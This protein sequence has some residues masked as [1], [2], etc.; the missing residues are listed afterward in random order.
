VKP[1]QGLSATVAAERLAADGPNELPQDRK[2]NVIALLFEMAREPMILLL[3]AAAVLYALIG[4]AKEAITLAASVV[5]MIA[6]TFAQEWKTERA[7]RS[8]KDLSSP[9]AQV[10]RDGNALRIPGRDVVRGD[11]VVLSEG[12]RVPADGDVIDA[13]NAL[14]DESILTGE[15]V[16]VQKLA[17]GNGESN[18]NTR[19]FSG[20]LVVRGRAMFEV[21]STGR[22]AELGKIGQALSE[23]ESE[24][25][26][27]QKQIRA[28]VRAFGFVGISS[29]TVLVLWIGLTKGDWIAGLLAGLALA[30]SLMP[31][32]FPVILTVFLA[33]GAYRMSRRHVLARRMAAVEALGAVSVLC[34]DK[35]GTLTENRMRIAALWTHGEASYTVEAAGG[36]LPERVHEV[37]EYGILSSQR[38]PFDP[39]E[40][41]FADLGL[42][43]LTGTEHLHDT[44]QLIRE[45]P[46]SAELLSISHVW[47][48][49]DGTA[50]VVAAKGAPEAIIDLCH[51]SD[52]DA[53]Q[54]WEQATTMA[55]QGLR[56]LG[57]ARAV[58]KEGPLP[59]IQ[60]DFIFTFVGLVGLADPLRAEVPA[61]IAESKQAGVR[62]IMITG[63]YVQTARTIGRSAGIDTTHVI[64]GA[65]L[66]ILSDEALA[67]RLA[68]TSIIARAIPDDKLRIVRA[69]KKSGAVVAMTGDGVNDAP[70]L[71]AAHVGIAMGGRGTDV[72]RESAGL[73]LTDDN[74]A[75]ILEGIRLGRRIFDNIRRASSYV[76]SVHV[77]IAGAALIPAL[78]GWPLSLLPVHIV[79]LELIIDPACSIA[80]EAEPGHEKAMRVPPRAIDTPILPRTRVVFALLQ[81]AVLMLAVLGVL[82]YARLQGYE[83]AVQSALAFSTLI[84]GNLS[85]IIVNRS[86]SRPLR[87][88]LRVRNRAVWIIVVATLVV[89]LTTLVA[90]PLQDLFHFARPGTTDLIGASLVGLLSVIW[91]DLLKRK[92]PQNPTNPILRY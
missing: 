92:R 73:V 18:D 25:S 21:S 46:L 81:G 33:L 14:V 56:V 72:A 26:P 66:R 53:A 59:E 88:V 82:F 63:D 32:E 35:T 24:A 38:D 87:E 85:L 22:N 80:F 67:E 55:E 41:A 54:I 39:M 75:S 76:L 27:L 11:W 6:I 7:L 4:D 29:C 23:I 83:V 74:F 47:R 1:P 37:V 79:F 10:I 84:V 8:L 91:I 62:V 16:P 43:T 51:I 30:I 12:D 50:L 49:P 57:V 68:Q 3:I 90:P 64:T 86:I 42:R 89:L 52:L 17:R 44:W 69:L 70:A 65:E 19:V 28:L 40:R 78:L 71:K 61:A 5:F 20:T 48:A 31:E 2:R 13:Q 9:R 77:A 15:S 58:Q 36:E 60:H 34:V 45:Y